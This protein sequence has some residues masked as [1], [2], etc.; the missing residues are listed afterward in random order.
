MRYE[1]RGTGVRLAIGHRPT[2]SLADARERVIALRRLLDDGIDPR[3]A[4]PSRRERAAP[5]SLSAAST[6][7]SAQHTVGHLASEFMERF[8]K[9][10]RKRPEYVQRI[11]NKDILPLWKDRDARTITPN[12]V[13]ELLDGIVDR[14][15]R[16]MA[17]HVAGVLAQLFRFGIHRKIVTQTPVQLLMRPGGKQRP[18]RRVLSDK[19]LWIFLDDPFACTRQQRLARVMVI[20]LTTGVRRGELASAKWRNVDLQKGVWR[21]PPEDTKKDAE[22]LVP[23]T[24]RA[25]T[26]FKALKNAAGRSHY[27]LPGEG[28]G[29]LDAKYLTRSL[30]RCEK[31]FKEKG[32]GKF[33]L[34]D[35]RRTLRTGLGAL[36]VAPDIRRL[37]VGHKQVGMDATY[38]VHDYFEEKR[39]ALE[40]WSAHL[41]SLKKPK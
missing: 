6:D 5:V 31:R 8:V 34:H 3:R 4:R 25:V 24:D 19:E 28:G 35:L 29:P 16:V 20:L 38:D 1:W 13:I 39:E 27:V 14:G 40:K 22:R 41:K 15:S 26:E 2:M 10:N 9:P 18:R 12:E 36:K 23:L 21:L 32:I 30:A 11:L 33:V 37:V 7:P 17:N